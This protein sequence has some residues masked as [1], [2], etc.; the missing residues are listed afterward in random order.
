[1]QARAALDEASLIL[2]VVDARAGITP[3]DEELADLARS[4]HKPVFV[5]ANK[6]DSQRLE[7]DAMEFE[8]WGFDEVFPISAEHGDGVAELLDRALEIVPAP[9]IREG[10]SRDVRIAIVGRPNVG[11]SSLV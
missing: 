11:K 4:M 8:R 3:L 7:A 1:L 5:A 2:L 6:V 9:A 10:A